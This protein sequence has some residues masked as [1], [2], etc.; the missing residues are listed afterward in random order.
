MVEELTTEKKSRSATQKKASFYRGVG[1]RKE[2]TATAYIYDKKMSPVSSVIVNGC[3]WSDYFRDRPLE[4]KKVIRPL[5]ATNLFGKS[6]VSVRVSGGGRSGQIDAVSLAIA[7]A[8]VVKDPSFKA[9]LR[10]AGLVTR[11]PR[12]KERKKPGLL[13]AR[14]KPQFAKR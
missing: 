5:E 9:V 7:R 2:A 6:A 12:E 4:S 14:K 8:I 3:D 13:R 10:Q 1:R 11:D